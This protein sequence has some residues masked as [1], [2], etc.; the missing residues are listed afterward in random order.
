LQVFEK[1][2]L[3]VLLVEIVWVDAVVGA[4]FVEEFE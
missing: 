1:V 4:K 3:E 2:V